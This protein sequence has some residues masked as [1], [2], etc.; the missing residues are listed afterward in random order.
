MV[1]FHPEDWFLWN[2][3][4]F[5]GEIF[6]NTSQVHSHMW[7]SPHLSHGGVDL[8]SKRRQVDKGASP[9][10][11]RTPGSLSFKPLEH[12]VAKRFWC[13]KYTTKTG[14]VSS[15]CNVASWAILPELVN[16]LFLLGALAWV[17]CRKVWMGVEVHLFTW[18]NESVVL[19]RGNALHTRARPAQSA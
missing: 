16:L 17:M 6:D 12:D 18:A 13:V 1:W 15:R 9:S 8:S 5:S 4:C 19:S 11:L 14:T 10:I 3:N 2:Q 7:L